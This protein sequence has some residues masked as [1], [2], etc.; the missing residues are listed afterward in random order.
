ME[1]LQNR[2]DIDINKKLEKVIQE[3]IEKTEKFFCKKA[4]LFKETANGKLAHLNA[5]SNG[6]HC[7]L[8]K[9]PSQCKWTGG[10]TMGTAPAPAS[11]PAPFLLTPLSLGNKHLPVFCMKT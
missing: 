10:L 11:A 3:I 6:Q 4:D 9:R 8:I 2:R 1:K 7:L 5:W